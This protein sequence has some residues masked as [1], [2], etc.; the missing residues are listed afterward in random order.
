MQGHSDNSHSLE[1]DGKDETAQLCK[2]G[3]TFSS[4]V[5]ITAASEGRMRHTVLEAK[6]LR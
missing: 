3:K 6:G 4:V 1:A 5:L 2:Q